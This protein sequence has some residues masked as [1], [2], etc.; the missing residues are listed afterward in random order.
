L[1][2]AWESPEDQE[3]RQREQQ[4]LWRQQQA[5]EAEGVNRWFAAAFHL[6]RLIEAEPADPSLYARRRTA[7][8]R[9][10]HWAKAAV[11][12]L[13]EAVLRAAAKARTS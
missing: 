11:D 2:I 9:Q 1:W 5:A 13:L 3:K 6:S 4:R 8:I 10:G 12:L 7:H